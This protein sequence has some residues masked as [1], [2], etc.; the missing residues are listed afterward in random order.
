M[1]S[2]RYPFRWGFG[3]IGPSLR[4]T[5]GRREPL[6]RRNTFHG[7]PNPFTYLGVV[8]VLRPFPAARLQT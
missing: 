1:I 7:L 6:L 5:A 3:F 8:G 2:H 4:R